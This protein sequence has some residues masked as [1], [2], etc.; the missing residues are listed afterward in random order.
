MSAALRQLSP[1]L[2]LLE[3]TCNVYLV[4]DGE[5]GLVIDFGSGG[6]LELMGEAGVSSIDWVLHTHHHRDQ[7]QGDWRA[8]AQRIPIAAPEHER[9]LF[10]DVENFWRNR[11]IF[12]SERPALPIN[13]G[14]KLHWLHYVTGGLFTLTRDVPVAASLRDYETFRWNNRE[15]FILPTPGHTRGSVTLVSIIDGK[16]VPDRGAGGMGRG[17]SVAGG[18]RRRRSG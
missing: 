3:D 1:S 8:I 10:E 5:R 12:H 11:R 2:Y 18:D 16:R 9:Y 14:A 13:L 7:A 4:K 6:I 17:Q 15:F